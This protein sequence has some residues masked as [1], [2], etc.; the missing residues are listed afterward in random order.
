MQPH[1]LA[2][3]VAIHQLHSSKIA[4]EILKSYEIRHNPS[5][6]Y[7]DAIAASANLKC[8]VMLIKTPAS[9]RTGNGYPSG[10]AT[11]ITSRRCIDVNATLYKRHVPAVMYVCRYMITFYSG[12]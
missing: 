8:T 5:L 4:K 9:M 11:L 7:S 6:A 3:I 2:W 10:H 12:H 1:N